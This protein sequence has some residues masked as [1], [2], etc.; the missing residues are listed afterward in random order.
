[1][2]RTLT[3][4]ACVAVCCTMAVS[5]KNAKTAEPTQEEIQAQKVALADSVLA[6]ID[7][8]ADEFIYAAADG[9]RIVNFE[10]TEEEIM[11]KPDYLLD[12][13][14]A[15]TLV[16]KSQK[17][18]ALAVFLVELMVR[19][20]YD[21]PL[22][23]TKEVMAKLAVELNHPIDV[24]VTTDFE[25]QASDKIRKEY[26]AFKERGELAYFWQFQNAIHFETC[27]VI[28]QNPEMFIGKITDDQWKLF[29]KVKR[30][31]IKGIEELAN[32]DEEMAVVKIFREA[33]AVSATKEEIEIVSNSREGAIRFYIKNKDKYDARRNALL[34]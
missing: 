3:L 29:A 13:S 21:M 14:F 26:E 30:A 4:I 2:K 12:P 17:I 7:A 5:C 25:M 24:N 19:K 1:M 31:R 9:F 34:Q 6:E 11:V 15:N 8:I 28:A 32:Y 27:Y 18:N 23:E 33:N 22:E 10:L 20:I 16:S